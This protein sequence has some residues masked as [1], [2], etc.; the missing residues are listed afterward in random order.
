MKINQKKLKKQ[1][2]IIADW[3]QAGAKGTVSAVTGFGKSFIGILIIKDMNERH[4]DRT[5]MIVV[6]TLVLKSQWEAEIKT[7]KL[8]NVTVVVINTVIRNQYD[9]HLLILDE[10]H[11][12]AAEQFRRVFSAVKYHFILGLTA[13]LERED[14]KHDLITDRAPV[15]YTLGMKE[16]RE[17]GYVSDFRIYNIPLDM[18]EDER[19]AYKGLNRRFIYNF[20]FF[21]HDFRRAMA[22]LSDPLLRQTVADEWD[23]TPQEIQVAAINFARTMQQRKK[24]LNEHPRKGCGI[25]Q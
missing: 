18:E 21:N 11:R 17:E 3:I 13:T 19:E 12:Y 5:T 23:M 25:P 9:I 10:V 2:A 1:K 8:K 20:R 14:G 7:H 22:A 6:P 4:P 16:A 24:I 15:I